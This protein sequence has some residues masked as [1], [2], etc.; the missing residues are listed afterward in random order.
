V[1]NLFIDGVER[2]QN[3]VGNPLTVQNVGLEFAVG[4]GGQGNFAKVQ[5]ASLLAVPIPPS[6]FL[7]GFSIAGLAGTGRRK[8]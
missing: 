3:Y 2:I 1:A 8:R 7:F 5:L 6:L 4:S